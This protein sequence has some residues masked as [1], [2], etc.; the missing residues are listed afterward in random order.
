[1]TE[2]VGIIGPCLM[3]VVARWACV[4]ELAHARSV[5]GVKAFGGKTDLGLGGGGWDGVGWHV[6]SNDRI[7]CV[8]AIR[9]CPENLLLRKARG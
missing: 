3:V 2:S 7:Q 5:H 8:R 4:I 6:V 1:M 9:Y